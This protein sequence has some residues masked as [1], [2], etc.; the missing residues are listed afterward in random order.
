MIVIPLQPRGSAREAVRYLTRSKDWNGVPRERVE[1]VSRLGPQDWVRIVNLH[2]D[3]AR[4]HDHLI[5]SFAEPFSGEARRRALTAVTAFEN[6][7]LGGVPGGAAA[8]S[9]L[10]ASEKGFHVHSLL[11]RHHALS[12]QRWCATARPSDLLLI[13]MLQTA[14]NR[15]WGFTDPLDPAYR[16]VCRTLPPRMIKVIGATEY[17]RV[18]AF[19]VDLTEARHAGKIRTVDEALSSAEE[20]GL[21]GLELESGCLVLRRG[22]EKATLTEPTFE[23]PLP[24]PTRGRFPPWFTPED[25]EL[26]SALVAA[27]Q[28]RDFEKFGAWYPESAHGRRREGYSFVM[29]EVAHNRMHDT[30]TLHSIGDHFPRLTPAAPES[31]SRQE[32]P[33]KRV[34]APAHDDAGI[35]DIRLL[36][37]WWR[38]ARRGAHLG[39]SPARDLELGRGAEDYDMFFDRC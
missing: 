19:Q 22:S 28:Q 16:R 6:I 1:V 25:F 13:V 10:H 38:R 29:A 7:L 33:P 20:E 37:Q 11:S 12:E 27:R 26:M 34:D 21:H 15:E 2:A 24:K 30:S 32:P 4:T 9:V 17:R 5:F 8:L 14:L 18:R 39:K 3:H 36:W 35:F 31:P 23:L